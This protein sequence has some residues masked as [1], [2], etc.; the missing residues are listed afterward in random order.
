MQDIRSKINSIEDVA[1]TAFPGVVATPIQDIQS[2]VNSVKNAIATDFPDAIEAT[3]QE[4]E[5]YIPK[6]FSLGTKEFCVGIGPNITCHDL[7]LILSGLVPEIAQNLSDSIQILPDT[8]EKSVQDQ[9]TKL[10]EKLQEKLQPLERTLKIVT[11][12]YIRYC[13]VAG[14]VFLAVIAIVLACAV[15]SGLFSIMSI[16]AKLTV[17]LRVVMVLGLICCVLLFIPTVIVQLFEA[18]TKKL[19]SGIRVEKGEV[20][21]L[22]IGALCCAV[23]MTIL[24][25]IVPTII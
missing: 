9:L 11:T 10:Q 1:T 4:I 7:P 3:I 2:K 6:N 25:M 24:T 21:G 8:L 14:L 23:V 5:K 18:N 20:G 12:P 13:L 19:P 17:G 22:C 15:F 16:L